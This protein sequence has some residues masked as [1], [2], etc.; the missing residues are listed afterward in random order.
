MIMDFLQDVLKTATANAAIALEMK[1]Q[2]GVIKENA[3]ADLAVFEG[4][5][6]KDF[7]K[8]LFQ[9]KMVMKD[10]KIQYQK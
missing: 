1:D 6:K 8:S 10:G 2:I 7:K 5:L 9:V 4:D 3:F